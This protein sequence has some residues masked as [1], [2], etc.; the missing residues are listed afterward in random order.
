M[1]NPS[2]AQVWASGGAIVAASRPV[3]TGFC[4]SGA[5]SNHV[6]DT[7]HAPPGAGVKVVRPRLRLR[8]LHLDPAALLARARNYED[9]ATINTTKGSRAQHPLDKPRSFTDADMY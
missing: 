5:S 4:P 1:S 7:Q 3:R 6:L 9:N 2:K 8:A